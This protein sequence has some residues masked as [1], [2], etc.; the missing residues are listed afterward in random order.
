MVWGCSPSQSPTGEHCDHFRLVQLYDFESGDW[1]SYFLL[2]AD[3]ITV[4]AAGSQLFTYSHGFT[5][6]GWF[7]S[8]EAALKRFL[9]GSDFGPDGSRLEGRNGG[10]EWRGGVVALHGLVD[11]G[12][13]PA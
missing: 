2:L 3:F 4:M 8:P 13:A 7:G 5:G 12:L 10:L 9:R 1:S 11:G 6:D